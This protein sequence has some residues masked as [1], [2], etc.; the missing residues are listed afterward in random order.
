MRRSIHTVTPI[1]S[2]EKKT[3]DNALINSEKNNPVDLNLPMHQPSRIGFLQP[4]KTVKNL[5]RYDGCSWKTNVTTPSCQGIRQENHNTDS[6]KV[7]SQTVVPPLLYE[8]SI[9]PTA[10]VENI[11]PEP[12][13]EYDYDTKVTNLYRAIE[14][15]EWELAHQILEMEEEDLSARQS[16]P[17]SNSASNHTQKEPVQSL[18]EQNSFRQ[19]DDEMNW[20]LPNFFQESYRVAVK[21]LGKTEKVIQPFVCNGQCDNDMNIISSTEDE[22]I[23]PLKQKENQAA[24]WI[25]RKEENGRLRWRHLPLHAAVIFQAPKSLIY[26]LLQSYPPAAQSKDDQGM[27]PLHLAMRNQAAD[28]IIDDLLHSYPHAI[29]VKDRK[30]RCPIEC[31][32]YSGRT[33]HD[34]KVHTDYKKK[35]KMI[36]TYAS[37]FASIE[38]SN[39]IRM[40]NKQFQ[41]RLETVH[42]KN[43]ESES[44]KLKLMNLKHEDE[45]RLKTQKLN[46]D[47]NNLSK[48]NELLNEKLLMKEKNERALLDKVTELIDALDKSNACQKNMK[49]RY[50]KDKNE[51]MTGQL[52]LQEK[53][54]ELTKSHEIVLHDIEQSKGQLRQSE[55]DIKSLSQINKNLQYQNQI[56]LDSRNDLQKHIENLTIV[57]GSSLVER[58]I[59]DKQENEIQRMSHNKKKK[60]FE[61]SVL[62]ILRNESK[63]HEDDFDEPVQCRE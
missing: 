38:R 50:E 16:C 5:S 37:S 28:D 53:H 47:T 23:R 40:A 36:Q 63:V 1:F 56:L 2:S 7:L 60:F 20:R 42:I 10:E 35:N 61:D 41:R 3:H 4:P 27:L 34:G 39:L 51:L 24:T 25:S 13:A 21:F 12:L 62:T 9:T 11:Q 6:G 48:E 55:K 32:I 15:R 29:H 22:I 33:N 26:D 57:L 31:A 54:N 49:K 58:H 19:N 43:R 52:D 45:L 14:L 46:E 44:I 30:G 8:D 17:E 59:L 18:A